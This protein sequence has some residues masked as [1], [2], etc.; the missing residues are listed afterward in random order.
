MHL[1]QN[2]IIGEGFFETFKRENLITNC[3]KGLFC[4]DILGFLDVFFKKMKSD[5]ETW[6]S[7]PDLL[8]DFTQYGMYMHSLL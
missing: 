5:R 2:Y 6:A 1:S 3:E 7:L 4:D 8:S